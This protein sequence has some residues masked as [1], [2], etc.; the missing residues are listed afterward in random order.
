MNDA[1]E[2]FAQA[3]QVLH[4]GTCK[5][6]AA[7]PGLSGGSTAVAFKI[8]ASLRGSV[9]ITKQKGDLHSRPYFGSD[10]TCR[11]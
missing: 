7:V 3:K 10:D 11:P 1:R 4:R 5:G 6:C 2:P 8:R 9:L